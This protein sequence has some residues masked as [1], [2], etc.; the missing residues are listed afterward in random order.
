MGFGKC[1]IGYIYHHSI[2]EDSFTSLQTPCVPPI[3][4]SCPPP[5]ILLTTDLYTVVILL[6]FP[7]CR[8]VGITKHIAFHIGF[9]HLVIYI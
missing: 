3:C 1:M 2:I 4:P 6:P 9:F 7:E 5:K 8:I